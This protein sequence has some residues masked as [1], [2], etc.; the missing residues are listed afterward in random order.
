MKVSRNTEIVR[1]LFRTY[2]AVGRCDAC[3]VVHHWLKG[4]RVSIYKIRSC[5]TDILRH[6]DLTKENF[7]GDRHSDFHCF[8]LQSS[9]QPPNLNKSSF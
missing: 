2:L 9:L 1:V 5:S 8:V 4:V 3:I 6:S 7:L